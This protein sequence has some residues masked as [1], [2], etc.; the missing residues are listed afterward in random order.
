MVSVFILAAAFGFVLGFALGFAARKSR[1][2][3]GADTDG[4]DEFLRY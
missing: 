3:S 4:I 1:G 2:V